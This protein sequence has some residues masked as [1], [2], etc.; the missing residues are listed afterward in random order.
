MRSLTVKYAMYFNKKYKRIGPLFQGVYKAVLV[1][2]EPQLVYLSKYIHR[3]PIE[4]TSSRVLEVYPYSSYQNYLG[5]FNQDWVKRDEILD[6]FSKTRI[7]NSYR[8]FVEET[9]ERDL[10]MVKSLVLEDI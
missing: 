5:K 2:N 6:Y 1:E 10:P 4:L 7:A 9:D 8:A 3:N